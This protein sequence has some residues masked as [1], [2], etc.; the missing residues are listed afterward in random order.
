MT[1]TTRHA[2]RLLAA[3]L[4]GWLLTLAP[5]WAQGS[6]VAMVTDLQGRASL[7]SGGRN[8]EAAMLA[9]IDAGAQ[10]QVAAGAT[11]VVLYL[12][13]GSEYQFK[14]P[15][16]VQ[17]RAD[18][19]EVLS[20]APAVRR[21]APAGTSLRLKPAGVS[22]GAI[23]MRSL[24][25]V[26]IRLTSGNGT[27]VLD[28]QPELAWAPPQPDLRYS[29]D[30]ADDGG[31]TVHKAEV[32]GTSLRVPASAGL[33]EGASYTWEVSARAPDGR[34]FSARGEFGVAPA[35]LREQVAA[36]RAQADASV[37]SQV[38]LALWLDQQELRDDGRRI[39]RELARQRPE[40]AGLKALAER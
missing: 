24:G 28:T 16:Q 17:F 15:A 22:Q 12:A 39:W 13:D 18:R 31:R 35:S 8:A 37:S 1:K 3:W 40:E 36:A 21:G 10:A 38:A 6:A 14:G 11:L 27:L 9:N 32:E 30:I 2:C 26:R 20:G 29:L 5:A 7:S 23:V 33:R 25:N 4:A 19:P 34:R